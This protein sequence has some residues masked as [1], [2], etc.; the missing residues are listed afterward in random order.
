MSSDLWGDGRPELQFP[1]G[2]FVFVMPAVHFSILIF[3]VLSTSSVSLSRFILA[4]PMHAE[5]L[6]KALVHEFHIS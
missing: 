6:G 4:V 2:D 5:V 3:L 1:C